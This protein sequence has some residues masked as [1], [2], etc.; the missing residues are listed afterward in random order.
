MLAKAVQ[1]EVKSENLNGLAT[2]ISE[3]GTK[4]RTN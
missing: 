3:L 4:K 2:V 1:K